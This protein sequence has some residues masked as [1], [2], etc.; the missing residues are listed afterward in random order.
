MAKIGRNDPCPCGSGRKFKRCH[1]SP[2]ERDRPV[3]PQSL[4]G[5]NARADAAGVQRER[6]Q[7]LG[8]PIIA[9]TFK[10]R[11][12][13]GVKNRLLHSQRW[14]TF[15]DF[16]MDYIKVAMGTGWG[17]AELAKPV[18]ERHPLLTW[19]GKACA[20]LNQ[21]I[22]EPGKV[23]TTQGS[24]AVAAYLH[25]AYDLYSLDHNA[26]LQEK[27]V[28]RLRDTNNFAGARYEVFVAASF[29]RAGFDIEFEN[30]DDR[31]TTHCEFT[32][33]YRRTG[34]RFSVEAKRRAGHRLRI[35]SLLNNALSKHADHRR[36]IFIDMN[37][38]DDAVSEKRP[39]FLEAA[40]TRLRSFE[41]KPLSG[42]SRPSAYVFVTN[43]PW[44]LH[45]DGPAPRCTFLV[46]GFQIP[47]FKSGVQAPLRDV[48]DAREAHIEMHE[49]IKSM[50]DH[51]SIPSTF[52]GEIPEYAFNPGAQRIL[53]GE[54]YMVTDAD[55]VERPAEVTA[56]TVA[57]S[58][59]LAYCGV[60]FEDGHAAIYTMA[61][62]DLELAAWR[63]HP[64]TFFGVVGQRSSQ[65]NTPLE[66]YDAI[67]ESCRRETR[68]RLLELMAN[69]PDFEQFAELDQAQLASLYAERLTHAAF[70]AV[71]S[72]EKPDVE[73]T[74]TAYEA[75]S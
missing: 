54:H 8:K 72:A 57:E 61:L 42:R 62:S 6:Q 20:C 71:P 22:K 21:A 4:S 32:A 33:T 13:V 58:Q 1:G 9:A 16:L 40:L 34:A 41:G 30:E 37:A 7:G 60:R 3:P 47:D 24:G 39:G 38:V 23:H 46:E 10:G 53:I 65:A 29:I 52:D 48:I 74:S 19:Y 66:F 28:K 50:K 44:D 56:A 18:E 17:N 15:E 63:R 49:L 70:A 55:G 14:Q 27:L 43:Y 31:A 35:G 36:V 12:L 73:S 25:L 59:Q 5:M 2:I 11:R 51:A 69:A 67:H 26:E 75:E 68:Q 64:D 45:L